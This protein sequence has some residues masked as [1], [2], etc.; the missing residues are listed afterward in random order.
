MCDAFRVVD[1]V[2]QLMYYILYSMMMY[3]YKTLK[4]NIKIYIFPH[5]FHLN[6]FYFHIMNVSKFV[7]VNCNNFFLYS[8]KKMII[9]IFK[10]HEW[11]NFSC[12]CQHFSNNM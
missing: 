11:E 5:Y 1:E 10:R 6:N 4:H 3:F 2:T 7:I 8:D 12:K 9:F